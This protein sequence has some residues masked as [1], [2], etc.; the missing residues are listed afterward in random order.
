[1]DAQCHVSVR[2]VSGK[3]ASSYVVLPMLVTWTQACSSCVT[4][5][6]SKAT[7][8]GERSAFDQAF[9]LPQVDTR[10][11][12]R[13]TCRCAK[14]PQ[15]SMR[16]PRLTAS[17]PPQKRHSGHSADTALT[18]QF[19]RIWLL[20]VTVPSEH[21]ST[22][23]EGRV[24][25]LLVTISGRRRRNSASRVSRR[26]ACFAAV[27]RL[28]RGVSRLFRESRAGCFASFA[29]VSHVFRAVSRL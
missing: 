5:P 4:R 11:S 1:M 26:F 2:S 25:N 20:G 8:S 12:M 21:G 19:A 15:V 10:A 3:R 17:R 29:A 6:A 7:V 24:E 9:A 23:S 27:S 13:H 18:Y 22:K 14:S 28:F 16:R